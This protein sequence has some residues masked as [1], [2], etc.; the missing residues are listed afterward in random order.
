MSDSSIIPVVWRIDVEPD[1]H[2]PRVRQDLW[3]GFVATVA[4]VGELRD[5]LASKSGHA[6]HPT[7]LLRM[8]PDIQR[9][10]GDTNYAVRR[11]AAQIDELYKCDDPM[12]IHVHHYRWNAD[13]GAAFSDHADT[14]WT[15]HCLTV[16]AAGFMSTFGSPA[17]RCSH[18]AYFLT[19]ALLDTAVQ[20]GIKVDLTVEPGVAPTSSDPSLGAYA[21]APSADFIECPQRPYYP[22][23]RAFGIPAP[24]ATDSRPIL[25][26]PLTAYDYE[27]ALRTWYRRLARVLLNRPNIHLPLSPWKDWKSPR[28]YWDLVARAADEQ[29]AR[30]FAFAMRTDAPGSLSYGRVRDLLEYLPHHPICK[31]LQFVDPLGPEI[32]ALANS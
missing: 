11:H 18:G 5:P 20:L 22:S 3:E 31:R 30:Y 6:V 19:E 27:S 12:G 13:R 8:D 4:L 9:C 25:I 24:S 15:T 2:Q 28:L 1:Q 7:W 32:Q 26:V 21:T 14:S 16:A 29:P 10:F 17:M 23:R